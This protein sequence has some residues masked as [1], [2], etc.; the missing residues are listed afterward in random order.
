MNK[1]PSTTA[2]AGALCALLLVIATPAS[3][4]E[5]CY[6]DALDGK[7]RFYEGPSASIVY[8]GMYKKT[9]VRLRHLDDSIPQGAATWSNWDGDDD[10]LLFTAYRGGNDAYVMGIDPKTG[11]HV[12]TAEIKSF[13]AGGIAV[14]EKLGWAY[15]SGVRRNGQ[16]TVA[17]FSLDK[18][19]QAIKKNAFIEAETET[20]VLV[21]SSFLTSHGPTNTLWVGAFSDDSLGVME[22]YKVR[23]DGELDPVG[24]LWEVPKK[25]QGLVV[26]KDLFI[27]S[28]SLGNDNRSNIYVVR[29]GKGE[30]KLSRNRLYCFR[31][32]S[33]AEGM[34]RYGDDVFLIFESAA[35]HYVEKKPRNVIASAHKVTL[36]AL[37]TLVPG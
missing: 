7:G 5:L 3:S 31:A 15:V 13:H 35:A 23:A 36:K 17:H 34:T 22:A 26:T 2:I 32:P 21:A 12:G 11:K 25:T 8:D 10:L 27:F 24:E 16:D 18:L 37:D 20:A 19:K 6:T 1:A 4:A 29:R 33:M 28:T 14:F 9:N 30:Q